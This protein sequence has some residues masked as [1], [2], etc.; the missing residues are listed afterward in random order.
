MERMHLPEKALVI[1]L[2]H[3]QT[4]GVV[5][6]L[7]NPG[8]VLDEVIAAGADGIMTSY[9]VVKKFGPQIFGRVPTSL[10]LDGGPSMYKE[11]WL[12]YT[13]WSLLH[14]SKMPELSVSTAS[15]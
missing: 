13:E 3:A 2:D 11:D 1:A 7:E 10:R 4:L 6:G 8:Q 15:V 5:E 14:P 9:G 12:K